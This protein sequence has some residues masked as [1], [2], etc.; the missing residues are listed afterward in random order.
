MF[1][2]N[3]GTKLKSSL[4]FCPQCG[5]MLGGNA[6]SS[7]EVKAAVGEARQEKASPAQSAAAPAV[8]RHGPRKVLLARHGGN[9]HHCIIS[10]P[11]RWSRTDVSLL[12]IDGYLDAAI[13]GGV[14]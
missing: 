1:C 12:R 14:R 2:S 11:L 8:K 6:G 4:K 3:C 7:P 5:A 9:L 13:F 10:S